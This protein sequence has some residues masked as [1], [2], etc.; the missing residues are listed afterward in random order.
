[1]QMR[2]EGGR[3]QREEGKGGHVA[4]KGLA[5]GGEKL[6]IDIMTKKGPDAPQSKREKG[7]EKKR[8]HGPDDT[9]RGGI[10][11]VPALAGNEERG[12]G[13]GVRAN[14]VGKKKG[15]KSARTRP[16]KKRG[17]APYCQERKRKPAFRP[18]IQKR[19]KAMFP[20]GE[21]QRRAD[22]EKETSLPEKEKLACRS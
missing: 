9:G 15:G 22:S 11:Y 3:L 4:V 8:N 7:G 14:G 20:K 6:F 2:T 21:K 10:K 12:E 13:V 18:A 16:S 17:L 5:E 19:S 1:V